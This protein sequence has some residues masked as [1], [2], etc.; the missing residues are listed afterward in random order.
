M[1]NITLSI[2]DKIYK[3]MRKYSEI[4]WSEYVRKIIE[5]RVNELEKIDSE[6]REE[7]I[8]TMLASEDLLKKDWNNEYDSL[9]DKI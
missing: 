9:W 8:F 2:D 4:M 3:K 6:E 5:K 7:N 1:T